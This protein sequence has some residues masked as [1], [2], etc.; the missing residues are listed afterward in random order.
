MTYEQ[1]QEILASLVTRQA[2]H[3]VQAR[4]ELSQYQAQ[5]QQEMAERQ[6]RAE[7]LRIQG[8]QEMAELRANLTRTEAITVS[9]AIA[10]AKT[11]AIANS[12]ARAIEAAA[13][14]GAENRRLAQNTQRQLTELVRVV[15]QFVEATNTRLSGLENR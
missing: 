8:Q 10:L 7:E 13:N 11:E 2:E 12:N 9:N 6:A 3:E 1:M 14:E 15:S 5:A 4:Q